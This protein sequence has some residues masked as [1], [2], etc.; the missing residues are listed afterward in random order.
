MSPTAKTIGR[1]AEIERRIDDALAEFKRLRRGSTI[2]EDEAF[3]TAARG[4]LAVLA[5]ERGRACDFLGE[6][7][8]S[9][10]GSYRP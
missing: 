8:N 1:I 10:N 6:A 7:L 3:R 2:S 9:G 5:V 4:L